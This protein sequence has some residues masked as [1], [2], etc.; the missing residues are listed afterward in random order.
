MLH[1]SEMDTDEHSTVLMK[2]SHGRD[3]AKGHVTS[4]E[5]KQQVGSPPFSCYECS[6][7]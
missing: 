2:D 4:D 7:S 3:V 6:M 5:G 1:T